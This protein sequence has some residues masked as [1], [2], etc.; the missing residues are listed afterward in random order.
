M[1]RILADE[2]IAKEEMV[3]MLQE[4]LTDAEI[5][6]TFDTCNAFKVVSPEVERVV[7]AIDDLCAMMVPVADAK[8][9][10]AGYKRQC[11]EIKEQKLLLR[12]AI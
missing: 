4:E 5:N 1:D 12:R 7:N 8:S 6:S 9:M 2:G 3:R 10:E 11:R